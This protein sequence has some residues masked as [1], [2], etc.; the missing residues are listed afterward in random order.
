MPHSPPWLYN[1]FQHVGTDFEDPTQVETYD[2]NQRS[3]TPETE[4]ALITQLGIFG[5]H[6]VIDLGCGT[7]TFAI[8]AALAGAQVFAID[9]SQNMLTYAQRK[10][11]SSGATN[12]QFH[13]AGFLTYEHTAVPVD[14]IV[15][16][17]AL[18]HLPDFWKMVA[19]QRM[20]TMLKQ[21]GTFYLRDV[22]F[23]FA[24]SD[25]QTHL[26]DWIQRMAKP[27]AEGWTMQDFETHI[28]E[29]YTTFGWILEGMLTQAGL[30]IASAHYPTPTYAE[31]ISTK[32]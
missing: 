27:V 8:Q 14:F 24:P 15:S 3:S 13:Q 17:F 6:T 10:A 31:Y 30:A 18:H 22:V 2:R 20:V 7:G 29:E 21:N 28:R 9:V 25:Y 32:L 5:G 1:E 19:F 4:Q 11:E 16:K 23:S 12:I 26:N